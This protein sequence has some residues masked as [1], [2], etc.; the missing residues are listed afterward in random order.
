MLHELAPAPEGQSP[1]GSQEASCHEGQGPHQQG[2]GQDQEGHVQGQGEDQKVRAPEWPSQAEVFLSKKE[3]IQDVLQEPSGCAAAQFAAKNLSLLAVFPCFESCHGF[4]AHVAVMFSSMVLRASGCSKTTAFH[5]IMTPLVSKSPMLCFKFI[6][7]V[8]IPECL[9]GTTTMIFI[10]KPILSISCSI[11]RPAAAFCG[12]CTQSSFHQ[13]LDLLNLQP[14]PS[15]VLEI[16]VNTLDFQSKKHKTT[17][18]EKQ[19]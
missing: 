2:P 16:I 12:L 4:R 17:D 8:W 15:K 11:K 6:Q 7:V 10:R 3:K 13:E 9:L 5:Q 14:K 19:R 1:S 18:L